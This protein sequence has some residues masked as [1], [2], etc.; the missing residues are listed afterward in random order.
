MLPQARA[1]RHRLER[2][3]PRAGLPRG[4]RRDRGSASTWLWTCGAQTCE[5]IHFCRFIRPVRAP[6]VQ[7]PQGTNMRVRPRPVSVLTFLGSGVCPV[8]TPGATRAWT[9]DVLWRL[10]ELLSVGLEKYANRRPRTPERVLL[11]PSPASS[12]HGGQASCGPW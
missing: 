10:R 6:L 4:L 12:Q 5:R 7:Q 3:E 8:F 9:Y 2:A 11:C 1:C